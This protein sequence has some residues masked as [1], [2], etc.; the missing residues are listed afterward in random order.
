VRLVPAYVK[1][2]VAR[3][4]VACLESRLS[5]V[6]VNHTSSGFKLMGAPSFESSREV[7]C[8]VLHKGAIITCT[9][10][11]MS[12]DWRGKDVWA[13]GNHALGLDRNGCMRWYRG[14]LVP[15]IL[16]HSCCDV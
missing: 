9:W 16:P 6:N 4:C 8:L 13:Q 2:G 12:T 14:G 11:S 10:A 15:I 1:N 5:D 7:M 3:P